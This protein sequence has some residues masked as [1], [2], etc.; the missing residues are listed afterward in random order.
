MAVLG[1]QGT[2]TTGGQGGQRPSTFTRTI[3]ATCKIVHIGLAGASCREHKQTQ[4]AASPDTKNCRAVRPS[5]S[6]FADLQPRAELS[7]RKAP[8]QVVDVVGQQLEQ[9]DLEEASGLSYSMTDG[10]QR[11]GWMDR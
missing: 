5:A 1:K 4:M 8:S 11:H 6:R 10:P 3:G 7:S 9:P 2:V